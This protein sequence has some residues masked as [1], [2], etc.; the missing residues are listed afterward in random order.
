VYRTN[1]SYKVINVIVR[2]KGLLNERNFMGGLSGTI[3]IQ[4]VVSQ[5][6]S[7]PSSYLHVETVILGLWKRGGDYANQ[8]RRKKQEEG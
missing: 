5:S 3:F 4:R 7:S 8:H 6:I 2:E 1:L